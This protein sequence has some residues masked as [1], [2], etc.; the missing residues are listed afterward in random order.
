MEFDCPLSN[1][2]DDQMF[3]TKF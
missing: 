2:L 1:F 3:N